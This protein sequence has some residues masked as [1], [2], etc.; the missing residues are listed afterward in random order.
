MSELAAE[1]LKRISTADRVESRLGGLEFTDG[2][3][4][5]KTVETLYDHLDYVHALN[6]FLTAFPAA[7]TWAIRRGLPRHRRQGQQR[8]DL[9]AVDGL[10]VAVPHRQ[11]RHR[12]LPHDR[13]PERRSDGRRDAADGARNLRRHV[14]PVD[15]RLRPP[16]PRPRRRRQVPP[17]SPRLRRHAPGGWLLRR[18]LAHQPGPHARALVHGGQ[19]SRADGGDHQVD[20]QGVPLRAG[21]PGHQCRHAPPRWPATRTSRQDSR[22]HVRRGQRGDLQHHPPERLRILGDRQRAGAGR[23]RSVPP[24]PRSWGTLPRSAS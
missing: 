16:R 12:L 19:R 24:T 1:V 6:G 4:S 5:A 18:S 3:P 7:S 8:P 2:A 21:W 14:V 17:R 13:R 15:H 22:H 11:R 9:L 20:A 10:V 23:S